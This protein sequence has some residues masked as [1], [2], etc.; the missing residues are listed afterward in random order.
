MTD[1]RRSLDAVLKLRGIRERQKQASLAEV[2]R[3]LADA[4]KRLEAYRAA[5]ESRPLSATGLTP[6]HLLALQLQG[7]STAEQVEAATRELRSTQLNVDAARAAWLDSRSK[8]RSAER[9]VEA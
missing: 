6:G 2:Q 3:R 9:V 4:S 1:R 5:H 8:R 7:V